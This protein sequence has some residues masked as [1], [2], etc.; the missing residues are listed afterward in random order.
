MQ[1]IL[2]EL[3]EYLIIHC[4]LK[5]SDLNQGIVIYIYDVT[6]KNVSS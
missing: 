6:V 3:S 4:I 1:E 2:W 5:Y